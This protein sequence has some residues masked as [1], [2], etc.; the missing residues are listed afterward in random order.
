MADGD[1]SES[2]RPAPVKTLAG[3][4]PP[5]KGRSASARLGGPRHPTRRPAL[6]G[7]AI[8]HVGP[9]WRAA[10]SDTSARL[11]GPRRQ[12]EAVLGRLLRG[13][14]AAGD[15]A[16]LGLA[17]RVLAEHLRGLLGRQHAPFPAL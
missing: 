7:R 1:S 14:S 4:R 6:A 8:R 10:P 11:G 3:G 15:P 13:L 17:G 12:T 5:P 9:P 2:G 16:V